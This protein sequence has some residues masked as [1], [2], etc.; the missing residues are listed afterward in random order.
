MVRALVALALAATILGA[1]VLF[2]LPFG[3]RIGHMV[4][5]WPG[6]AVR[7]LLKPVGIPMTGGLLSLS[8]LLFWWFVAWLVLLYAMPRR[9]VFSNEAALTCPFCKSRFPLTWRRYWRAAWGRH[10]CPDCGRK[11]RLRTG[12]LYWAL[13]VPAV[14]IAPFAAVCVGLVVYAVVVPPSVFEQGVMWFIEGPWLAGSLIASLVLLLPIDRAFDARFRSL[15][16][17][18]DVV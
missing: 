5:F 17:P 15:E 12:L 16:P 2:A 3:S 8:T 4:A 7:W 9:S 14:T 18:K 1:S 13:Y 11:S 6:I 10:A